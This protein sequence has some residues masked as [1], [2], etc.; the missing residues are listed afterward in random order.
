M[1]PPTSGAPLE[2]GQVNSTKNINFFTINVANLTL[3]RPKEGLDFINIVPCRTSE[4]K[5]QKDCSIPEGKM[6]K[7]MG[8]ACQSS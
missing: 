1:K 4:V 7:G 5:H 8:K 3:S 6:L 2:Q